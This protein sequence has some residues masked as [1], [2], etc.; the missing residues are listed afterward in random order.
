MSTYR[1]NLTIDE[2]FQKAIN[3]FKAKYPLMSETEI[4]KMGFGGF[5]A[6]DKKN[7]NQI[8]ADSLPELVL[9]QKQ[10]QN[11]ENSIQKFEQSEKMSFD[12]AQDFIS[13]LNT[14][15]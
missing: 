14:N 3:H 11:L 9:N 2:E 8:W 15:Q 7:D 5:Y 13:H 10:M 1:I 12:T 4:V 6:Q